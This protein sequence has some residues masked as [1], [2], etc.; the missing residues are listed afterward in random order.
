MDPAG[1]FAPVPCA[2]GDDSGGAAP[3]HSG[4]GSR[5]WTNNPFS[6]WLFRLWVRTPPFRPCPVLE[7]GD[8]IADHIKIHVPDKYILSEDR[9]MLASR[10]EM[11]GRETGKHDIARGDLG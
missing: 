2:R 5:S 10:L 8:V 7:Q 1:S 9:V 6:L 3:R 4:A 11:L